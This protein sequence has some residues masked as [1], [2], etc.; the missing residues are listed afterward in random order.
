MV[1][2]QLSNRHGFSLMEIMTIVVIIG[3]ISAMA[4]PKFAASMHRLEFRSAARD[5]VSKMRLARSTAI[6]QKQQFGVN[7]DYEGTVMTTFLDNNNPSL[8][9]F[10]GG[11]SVISVDSLPASFAWVWAESGN[12]IPTVIYKP[13]GSAHSAAPRRI[14]FLSINPDDYVQFGSIELSP[15][16]GRTKLES[17]GG[18][19]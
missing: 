19:F 15:A 16:T 13:N 2:K 1:I 11:D 12:Y 3:I 17:L 10:D 9:M 7:I 8:Y 14:R 18:Y 5:I 4:F 6:S